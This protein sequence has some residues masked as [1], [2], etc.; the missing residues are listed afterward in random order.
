MSLLIVK[1]ASSN[2]L[3]QVVNAL[4]F[5]FANDPFGRYIGP[6]TNQYMRSGIIFE[7]MAVASI[8]AGGSCLAYNSGDVCGAASL[9]FPPGDEP[10]QDAMMAA[11]DK[12]VVA[13]RLEI[14]ARV[15]EAME[16]FH[17]PEPH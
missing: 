15:F 10:P 1:T 2:D 12:A 7:A 14:V 13:R 11:L 9:W 8:E 6:D 16:S 4:L 3:Q 17:P 5:A